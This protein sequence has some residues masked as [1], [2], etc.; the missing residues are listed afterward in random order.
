MSVLKGAIRPADA[1]VRPIREFA[2]LDGITAAG[3]KL[4]AIRRAAVRF[5]DRFKAAG[6]AVAARSRWGRLSRQDRPKQVLPL[7]E[8]RTMFQVTVER[9]KDLLQ[10][11][12][13]YTVFDVHEDEAAAIRSFT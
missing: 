4:E 12:K 11:T 8:D 2:D 7:T 6:T 3:E 10:I 9:V 13:L 5:R 1:G